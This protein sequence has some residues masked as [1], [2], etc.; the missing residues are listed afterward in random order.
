MTLSCHLGDKKT[1]NATDQNTKIIIIHN[2]YFVDRKT[3]N[4]KVELKNY[5][6]D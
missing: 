6:L 5:F 4:R 2:L 1:Q 3:S